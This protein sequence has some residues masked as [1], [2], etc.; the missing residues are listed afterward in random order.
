MP[1]PR[2]Q[3]KQG[4]NNAAA[5]IAA[6]WKM[7]SVREKYQQLRRSTITIQRFFRKKLLRLKLE[8][9]VEVRNS[10]IMS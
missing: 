3:G 7:K 1:P 6:Y 10:R 8:Q 5:K 9:D 2:F 4:K